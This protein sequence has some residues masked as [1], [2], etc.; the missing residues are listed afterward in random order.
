MPFLQQSK[1]KATYKSWR[2]LIELVDASE[3]SCY[4]TIALYAAWQCIAGGPAITGHPPF[5]G[6]Q[7]Q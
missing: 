5:E 1:I 4:V 6:F 7:C 3:W 2:Y